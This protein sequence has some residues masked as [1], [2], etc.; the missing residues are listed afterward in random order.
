MKTQ[1]G[2]Y[3]VRKAD[4]LAC[5]N[6]LSHKIF[7]Q[8]DLQALMMTSTKKTS[9][10]NESIFCRRRTNVKYEELNAIQQHVSPRDEKLTQRNCQTQMVTFQLYCYLCLSIFGW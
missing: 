3:D 5:P 8:L 4:V 2:L 1:H 6:Q 7:N 9:F 10:I